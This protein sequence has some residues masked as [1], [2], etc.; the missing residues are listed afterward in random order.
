MAK[1][2]KN[3]PLQI[4]AHYLNFLASQK[5]AATWVYQFVEGSPVKEAQFYTHFK[6]I[7]D[8]EKFIWDQVFDKTHAVLENDQI[9]EECTA[10]E[11]LLSFYYSLL[12]ILA[13][14][15]TAY[16]LILNK[17]H[18]PALLPRFLRNFKGKYLMF[19]EKI[20]RAGIQEGTITDRMTLSNYYKDGLWL[21]CY[22]VLQFWSRDQSEDQERTDAAIEK[23]V[24]LSF[25]LM[26]HTAVDSMLSFGKFL[27]QSWSSGENKL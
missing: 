16:S 7:G 17:V 20:V 6:D 5:R 15:R 12:E 19:V 2:I 4:A 21:Q 23:A 1:D 24:T 11:K 26:G 10:P 25:E 9:Y 3:A 8:L 13:E 27:Y 22:F 18:L 14:H